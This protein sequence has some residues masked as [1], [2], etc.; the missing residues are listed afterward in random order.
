MNSSTCP[1]ESACPSWCVTCC[2]HSKSHKMSQKKWSV[3]FS[4]L[5][6]GRAPGSTRLLG[7]SSSSVERF[8]DTKW[9]VHMGVSINGGI[10]IA[11][12]SS[13]WFISGK[14]YQN[15]FVSWKIWLKWMISGHPHWNGNLYDMHCKYC[16]RLSRRFSLH[17][18]LTPSSTKTTGLWCP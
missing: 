12:W 14:P 8:S 2:S 13:G 17:G 16:S 18:V 5:Q 6:M 10:S 3:P 11:G 1:V 7:S 9:M 4:G 15:G